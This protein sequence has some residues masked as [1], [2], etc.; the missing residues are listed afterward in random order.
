MLNM[1]EGVPGRAGDFRQ[2]HVVK[3]LSGGLKPLRVTPPSTGIHPPEWIR[4]CRTMSTL[5]FTWFL[6]DL[7]APKRE[8]GKGEWHVM[9]VAGGLGFYKG[10]YC[11]YSGNGCSFADSHFD[12]HTTNDCCREI[13]N[14]LHCNTFQISF[15]FI[16]KT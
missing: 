6:M 11:T 9:K 4:L 16:S 13:L 7:N 10:Y 14:F 5:C 1:L 3:L 8:R 15:E 12:M 2:L